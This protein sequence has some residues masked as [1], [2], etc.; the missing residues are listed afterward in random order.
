MAIP[1]AHPV[2]LSSEILPSVQRKGVPT[3]TQSRFR[4]LRSKWT[5]VSSSR[6]RPFVTSRLRQEQTDSAR[7]QSFGIAQSVMKAAPSKEFLIRSF[8]VLVIVFLGAKLVR[9]RTGRNRKAAGT[10]RKSD[11]FHDTRGKSH[12]KY[13]SRD[14]WEESRRTAHKIALYGA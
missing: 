13:K 9:R 1:I 7:R 10:H 5:S 6:R 3:A 2:S 8:F 12:P 11:S 4:K 14:G